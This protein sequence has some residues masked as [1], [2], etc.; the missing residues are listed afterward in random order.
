MTPSIKGISRFFHSFD[1]RTL[2]KID[3]VI[4]SHAHFDHL[5]LNTLKLIKGIDTMIVPKGNASLMPGVNVR[6]II[7]VLSGETIQKVIKVTVFDAQHNGS[8]YHP[9]SSS[10][11]ANS[12]LLEDGESSIYFA[13]DT[14]L[15]DHI[16]QISLLK[17]TISILPIGAFE[18]KIVLNYYHMNPE[19][20]LQ[21]VKILKT[22]VLI[23]SHFGTY[24]MSLDLTNEALPMLMNY[25]KSKNIRIYL[26][27]LYVSKNTI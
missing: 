21:A 7:E 15:G 8:R 23:P 4:I 14:G 2:G 6:Q 24:R 26:P 5:S 27:R 9:F 22:E 3:L 17:P 20:A 25:N 12:Y 13:G 18:P 19:Q 10:N 11:K 16:N 1:P